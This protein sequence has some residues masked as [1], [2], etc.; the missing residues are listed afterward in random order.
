M[1]HRKIFIG[2]IL[3]IIFTLILSCPVEAGN[4]FIINDLR[5]DIPE[6]SDSL[7]YQVWIGASG[8]PVGNYPT[9]TT[10][11]LSVDLDDRPGLFGRKFSQV[12]LMADSQSI[13]WF[14]YA[15]S[16]VQCLRGVYSYWNTT[17]SRYLGCKGNPNDLVEYGYFSRVE[18]VKYPG[19]DFWIAR[20]EDSH[21]YIFDVARI[22]SDSENIYDVDVNMEEGWS[23]I[24]DPYEYGV[25]HMWNPQYNSWVDGFRDWPPSSTN[26]KN[27]LHSHPVAICPEHYGAW[28]NVAGNLRYWVAGSGGPTCEAEMFTSK[29]FLPILIKN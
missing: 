14:V 6:V 15:E 17:L 3:L 24:Q 13:Y 28:I 27:H 9:F 11:W 7:D 25:F 8:G 5:I 18:L 20:I 22:W 23:Q 29:T 21:G 4:D 1:L 16:G 19:D 2:S 12:G 26:V 10:A